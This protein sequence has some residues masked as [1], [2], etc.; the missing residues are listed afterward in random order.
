ME[1]KDLFKD[2]IKEAMTEETKDIKLSQDLMGRIM[3]KREKS[4]REKL[5][6]ILNKEIEIPL[7]PVLVGI[8]GLFIITIIPKE[9]FSYPS[10]QIIDIGTSQIIIRD[11]DE[12][13]YNED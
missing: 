11:I 4:L 7:V 12:V 1:H 13:A 10:T 9:L 2:K 6:E 5:S 3:S 8:A